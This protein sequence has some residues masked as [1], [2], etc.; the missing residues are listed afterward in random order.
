MSGLLQEIIQ[1]TVIP[2]LITGIQLTAR[3]GPG[4]GLDPGDERRQAPG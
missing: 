3:F 1:A 4:G 2:V